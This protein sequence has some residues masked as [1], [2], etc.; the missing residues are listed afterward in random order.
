MR[1]RL[2]LTVV[3]LRE[4]VDDPLLQVQSLPQLLAVVFDGD[5][6]L[7]PN[8]RLRLLGGAGRRL[9]VH[10]GLGARLRARHGGHAR[11]QSPR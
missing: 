1:T 11:T 9:E 5:A 6:P 2:Y 7:L 3:E 10:P 8:R 4:L